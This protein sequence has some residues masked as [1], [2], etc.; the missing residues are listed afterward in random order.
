PVLEAVATVDKEHDTLTIYAVNRGQ[1]AALPLRG[2]LRC[3]EGYRI[4]EHLVLEH[5]D[6]KATNSAEAPNTV[7]PHGNGDA[8]LDGGTLTATLPRLSWNVI[9]LGTQ[10]S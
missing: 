6:P 8:S 9:R 5:P 10:K 2:D 3:F 7:V 1:D 4:V